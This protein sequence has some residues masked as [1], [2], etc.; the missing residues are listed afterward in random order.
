MNGQFLYDAMGGIGHDLIAEAEHKVFYKSAWRKLA[1]LAACLAVMLGVTAAAAFAIFGEGA[2][3]GLPAMA[4]P[5]QANAVVADTG[6]SIG[7]YLA[8]VVLALG[9]WAL[10]V[11]GRIFVKSRERR[12]WLSVL[13]ALCCMFA[14]LAQLSGLLAQVQL[15]QWGLLEQAAWVHLIAAALVLFVT[16]GINAAVW[17]LERKR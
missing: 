9:A 8:A 11:T 3:V 12:K 1:E 7:P 16:V 17:L 10:P 5:G 6:G 14:V 4:Q 15:R 2:R 13:S